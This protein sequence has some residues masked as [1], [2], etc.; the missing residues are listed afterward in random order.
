MQLSSFRQEAAVQLDENLSDSATITRLNGW[1]NEIKSDLC[2]R[3]EI[4]G[5]QVEGYADFAEGEESHLLVLTTEHN[6]ASRL[7]RVLK[8]WMVRMIYDTDTTSWIDS[9]IRYNLDEIAYSEYREKWVGNNDVGLPRF[10]ALH[11]TDSSGQPYA[12]LYPPPDSEDTTDDTGLRY[13]VYFIGE[14]DIGTLVDDADY[15]YPIGADDLYM[16]GLRWKQ[17][18]Y[19][20]DYI[21]AS[22]AKKEYEEAVKKFLVTEHAT[23]GYYIFGRQVSRSDGLP[24]FQEPVPEPIP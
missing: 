15:L 8:W 10:V 7:I 9:D 6:A 1:I 3:C 13:R 2:R 22:I 14:A 18:V 5:L 20:K 17:C 16:Q 19:D 12:Y 23:A 4:R 21:N 11:A 24:P